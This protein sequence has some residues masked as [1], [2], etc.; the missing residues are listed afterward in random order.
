MTFRQILSWCF[1]PLTMWYAV[2]VYLRNLL[3]DWGIK[4]HHSTGVMTVGVGNIVAGGA[5]K[6][7]HSEYFIRILKEKFN[8]V[9]LSRGY[10]RKS[11][12][13]Q[14]DDGSHN[15]DILGDEPAMI[16]THF[17]DIVTAV[18]EKRIEGIQQLL[19]QTPAPE[20]VVLDDIYQHRQIKPTVNI[21]LTEYNNLFINDHIIPFGNL[22]EPASAKRRANIVIVTKCPD[23]LDSL[24]RH[25]I[26]N[27]LGIRS[28]QKIFFSSIRY[29]ELRPFLGQ[30]TISLCNV[31]KVVA[32]SGIA[33]PALFEEHLAK[34]YDVVPLR[35]SDHHAFNVHDIQTLR[36]RLA[37][38]TSTENT[39]GE[40]AIVITEKDA[41]RLRSETLV[42]E[43][44]GLPIFVLPIEVYFLPNTNGQ[45]FDNTLLS[46]LNE[47]AS[48]RKTF[49]RYHK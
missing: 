9:Y 17:P 25:Q 2:G 21:L 37:I 13:F 47:N 16:A 38:L 15:P 3:Y 22:R 23:P 33:N 40:V 18:C 20:V 26:V 24:K 5:G 32:V 48:L 49:D 34:T 35:F 30:E 1:F 31:K 28:Y 29:G 11:K 14:I 12:G 39:N 7:P 41:S 42:G 6:T 45:T 43:L 36:E 46:L 10:K 27:E 4:K 19:K 44:S 8:V